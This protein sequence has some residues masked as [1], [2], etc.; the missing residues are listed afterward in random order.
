MADGTEEKENFCGSGSPFCI[1]SLLKSIVLP[2]IR[3]GVPVFILSD[4]KP[5]S[6]SCLLK[7]STG[8]SPIR[9]PG[10]AF[11]PINIFPF[12]KVPLV[13]ITVL[14]YI[15]FLKSVSTPQTAVSSKSKAA[16]LSCHISKFG[17][18]SSTLRQVAEN[19][20]LSHWALGL[21]IAGPLDLLS[22]L[23]CMV[24]R[25]VT[26]AIAPPSA[27]ISLTICPFAMPPI[28]GLQDM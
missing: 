11:H 6:E 26:C 27:S 14:A 21:H 9:P 28:A 12:K 8:G 19:S 22:I 4:C 10:V 15:L 16:T 23:N 2:S 24:L 25:S 7:P 17:V 5:R 3:G 18:C 1:S 13:R 20:I